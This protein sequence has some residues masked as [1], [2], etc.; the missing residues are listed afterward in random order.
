[1]SAT[2]KEFAE[3]VGSQ[4]RLD[5]LT[6]L[7]TVDIRSVGPGIWNDWKG[8]LLRNLYQA[9]SAYLEGRKELAPVSRAA[10]AKEQLI[11]KLSPERAQRIQPLLA[12]LGTTYWLSFDMADLVR[13]TR[14]YAQSVE[15]AKAI[16]R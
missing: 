6:V 8:V 9:T 3:L 13:H 2:I 12:E 4:A 1:L 14:F 5:M 16:M 7:T 10:A 11:E 15:V